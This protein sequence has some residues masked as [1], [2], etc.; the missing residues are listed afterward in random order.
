MTAPAAV[1]RF[2]ARGMLEA[3]L[4]ALCV[5]LAFRAPNFLTVE[6][7]LSVLRSVSMQGLIAFGMTMVIIVGEID[8]SVGALAAFAGCLLAYLTQR[9]LP[10]PL[11]CAA[12]VATGCAL[13]AFTGLMRA[14]FLV[15][16]FITTLALL[17]G[18]RGAALMVSGGF[19]ITSFPD[20]FA[21][22]GGG[23]WLGIPFPAIA[24]VAGFGCIHLLM[25]R[26]RFGR[27]VYATGSNPRA[28][29]LSGIDVGRVRIITLALTGG[30]A[31][32]SG[33]ML[34][35]RI[36]SGTPTVA[37]G[38]ELDVISAVIIGGT[39]LSGGS[40]SIWDTLVGTLFIGVVANGMTLL[41]IP[42]YQQYVVRALLI[43]GA[44]LLNRARAVES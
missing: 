8:L 11:G 42:I 19:P 21:F 39:S 25:S 22:L 23:E 17:T 35:A 34:S 13:G 41:D 29:R 4:L 9:G 32:F 3:V 18:L 26:T 40:G 33:I 12:T 44:V 10:I 1:R 30:L 20:W 38:W 24:L 5:F 27:A 2:F 15:P 36:M 28:A 31:A 6:N 7:L 16:S 37:Q 43:F 14:R